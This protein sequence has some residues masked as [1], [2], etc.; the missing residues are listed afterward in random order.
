MIRFLCGMVV[1]GALLV[2]NHKCVK[3]AEER[4][5]RRQ[6][7]LVQRQRNEID[8]LKGDNQYYRQMARCRDFY[9]MGRADRRKGRKTAAEE[10]AETWEDARVQF[11]TK[12]GD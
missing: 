12:K 6:D 8:Y 4:E 10:F 3:Q 7:A 9:E 2:L 1:G 5:R 11:G